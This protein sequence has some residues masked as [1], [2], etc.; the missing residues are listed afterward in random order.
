MAEHRGFS[1][2]TNMEVYFATLARPGSAEHREHQRTA[3]PVLH[4]AGPTSPHSADELQTVAEEL[5]DR[6]GKTLDWETPAERLAALLEA[7]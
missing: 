2:A 3:A 5:D 1:M 7:S 4:P 6:P